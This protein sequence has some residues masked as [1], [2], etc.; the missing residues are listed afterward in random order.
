IA[1]R[2]VSHRYSGLYSSPDFTSGSSSFGLSLDSSTG[3]SSGS[4]SNSLSDSS[5]LHSSGHDA[6]GRPKGIASLG[7]TRIASRQRIPSGAKTCVSGNSYDGVRDSCLLGICS[8][9]SDSLS[10]S[11]SSEHKKGKTDGYSGARG[12]VSFDGSESEEDE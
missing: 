7:R 5:S 6:S 11:E 9:G 8:A 10:A 1:W 2:R 3:I 12:K 4:S